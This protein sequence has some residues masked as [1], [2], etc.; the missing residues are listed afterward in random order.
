MLLADNGRGQHA[1]GRVERVNGRVD[2]QF[3][4]RARQGGRGVKVS[5]RG[6]RRRVGKVVRRNVD[7]LHR[8]D[9]ALGGRG[10]AF[11]QRAH[12]GRQGRLIAHRRRN[13][14]E[15]RRH[16]RTRLGEAE[17]VVDEEQHVLAFLVAEVLGHGQ[18]RKRN[19]GA[20]ARGLVHLAEHERHLG[21]FRRGVAIGVLGDNA[22]VEEFVVEVVTF[23][24]AFTDA[25]ED[26]HAAVA[27]GDVVD[28]FLDEHGLAH[29][30]AAE[31]ADL[32]AL[33]VRCEQVDHLDAGHEDR[34]FGRLVDEFRRSSVDRRAQVGVDRA[35]L[36]DRIADDVENAAQGLRTNRHRDLRASGGDRLTAG[37]TVGRVHRDGADG[38]FTQ[39]LGNFEH[40]AGA[41]VVGFQRRENRRQFAVEG[42]VDDGADDLAD[43]A[44]SGVGGGRSGLLASGGLGCC[45]H[46]RF[47]ALKV[48]RALR[49]PR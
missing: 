46:G 3:R 32:A 13:T 9:R 44:A 5:K 43:L 33:S 21:A 18:T 6:G 38:V 7:R 10:D 42:H 22:G 12:V 37:Q 4:D 40:Q 47:L 41:V 17:D 8:G 1:A 26:R 48:V 49:R 25:R 11:L 35:A 31:Q 29:A 28:Q 19:A 24:G 15:Q 34:G 23:A 20:G 30:G 36:V 39:V 2:A 14:A 27:L 16:F 45:G